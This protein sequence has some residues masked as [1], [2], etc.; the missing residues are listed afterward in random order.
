MTLHTDDDK[1]KTPGLFP[2][3]VKKNGAGKNLPAVILKETA[4][5]QDAPSADKDLT[6][7]CWGIDRQYA[8]EVSALKLGGVEIKQEG[9]HGHA[10][11]EAIIHIAR[12]NEVRVAR[13]LLWAAGFPNVHI[14]THAKGGNYDLHDG[15]EA[16][17]FDFKD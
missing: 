17:D 14:Y 3:A 2:D 5:P 16:A 6:E 7:G 4:K 11:E 12:G 1:T 9:Q 8:I 15:S 13:L 10:E